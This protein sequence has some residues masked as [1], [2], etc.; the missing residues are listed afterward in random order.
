MVEHLYCDKI[1]RDEITCN[2][3]KDKA[4]AKNATTVWHRKVEIKEV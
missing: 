3:L 1:S 4:L 2:L